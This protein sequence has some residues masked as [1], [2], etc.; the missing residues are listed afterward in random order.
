MTFERPA[1]QCCRESQQEL[2]VCRAELEGFPCLSAG[3]H[4]SHCRYHVSAF[5]N[6]CGTKY[7]LLD[8]KHS[9][10]QA[11][12]VGGQ[13]FGA[14]SATLLCASAAAVSVLWSLPCYIE[15]RHIT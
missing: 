14:A 12:S 7:I 3:V 15:E 10:V 1:A 9:L 11:V 6:H 8:T 2:Y 4:Y 13:V 5:G